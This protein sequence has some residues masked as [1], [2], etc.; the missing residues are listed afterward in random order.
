MKGKTM[1]KVK[2]TE[3]K[4]TPAKKTITV[5]GVHI[6]NSSFVDEEGNIA[7]RLSDLIPDGF[8]EF[9]M[10]MTFELPLTDAE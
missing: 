9:A 4:L 8:E 3:E 5:S 6:E 10:K 1:F 2:D 7:D